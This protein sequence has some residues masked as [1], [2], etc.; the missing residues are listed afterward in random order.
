[1]ERFLYIRCRE[2][3]HTWSIAKP[4]SAWGDVPLIVE[5]ESGGSSL[6]VVHEW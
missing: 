1:V 5:I 3:R 6:L 2:C 4:E